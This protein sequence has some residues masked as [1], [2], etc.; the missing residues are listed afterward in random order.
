MAFGYSFQPGLA[1]SGANGTGRAG[2]PRQ[3]IQEAIQM[4]SLRLPK[5]FGA[6]SIA[7]APLL[8]ALGSMGQPGARGNVTAQAYAQLAG[9]PMPQTLGGSMPPTVGGQAQMFGGGTTYDWLQQERALN[10]PVPR[11]MPSLTDQR[12]G[13]L[14]GDTRESPWDDA[15]PPRYAP[16]VAP[17]QASQPLPPG[18]PPPASQPLPTWSPPPPPPIYEPPPSGREDITPSVPDYSGLS[19]YEAAERE[20]RLRELLE[21]TSQLYSGDGGGFDGANLY[22]PNTWG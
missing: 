11:V 14:S 21:F 4:L 19:P 12:P 1:D 17:P 2:G 22:D 15:A 16:P 7:P 8:T 18:A 9:V 13:N 3:P 10:R 6:R 5:S 20:G